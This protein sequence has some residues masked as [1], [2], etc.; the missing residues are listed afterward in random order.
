MVKVKKEKVRK[1]KKQRDKIRKNKYIKK[2]K[3]RHLINLK[4]IRSLKAT[5]KNFKTE[6]DPLKL[7]EL[8][9][10][11]K[12]KLDKIG[13]KKI[14]HKNKVNRLKSRLEKIANK[15]KQDNNT[16]INSDKN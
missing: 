8:L 10:D 16:Q 3:S 14:Y 5:I 15:I 2:N 6:K 1:P 13:S 9:N 4:R 12:K 11:V 7:T